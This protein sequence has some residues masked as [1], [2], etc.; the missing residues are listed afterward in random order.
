MK[1]GEK[2]MNKVKRKCRD[3][4]TE[5]PETRYFNC[6]KCVIKLCDDEGDLDYHHLGYGDLTTQKKKKD[7][8]I[9]E[10]IDPEW[11]QM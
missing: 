8:G 11:D 10:I 9:V 5:L 6:T 4:G 3:C 7:E 1:S 2:I